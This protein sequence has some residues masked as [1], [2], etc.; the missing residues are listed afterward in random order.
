[1]P[2]DHYRACVFTGVGQPLETRYYPPPVLAPGEVL[3]RIRCCTLCGSD[4]H[5]Y[6]GRRST[7]S[8]SVLGHEIMG[9][10][11]ETGG[12]VAD[13]SGSRL[14]PGDRVSWS[15]MASCGECSRCRGGLP[16]KCRSLLKYGHEQLDE[17]APFAGGLADLCHLRPGTTICRVSDR[18]SDGVSALANCAGATAA[19]AMRL[20]GPLENRFVLIQGA[21]TLGLLA[22]A[23]ASEGGARS[24]LV[25]DPT[26]ARLDLAKRFGATATATIGEAALADV[27]RS[28]GGEEGVDV[29]LEMSGA[30]EAFESGVPALALGGVYVL[31]GG[32]LPSRPAGIAMERLVRNLITIR[33]LHNYWPQ[34]LDHALQFLD[35]TSGVF[36]YDNLVG[37]RYELAEASE[38]FLAGA[39]GRFCRVAVVPRDSD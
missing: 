39:A 11:L 13:H 33:G 17:S 9:L 31:V 38:A 25:V 16:Q 22:C 26:P 36:P 12:N 37:E 27:V 4:L 5:S 7:P 6:F 32:A 1:M 35:R 28:A 14:E 10:V 21:G 3:V 18:I 24:I 2:L 30:P 20:A 34:D 8:P 15:V 23:M 29:A 19:A